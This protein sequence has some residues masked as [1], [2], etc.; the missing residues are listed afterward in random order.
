MK[1]VPAVFSKEYIESLSRVLSDF[2][3]AAFEAMIEEL[4]GAYHAEKTIFVMGNGG[5]AS[6][7]SHWVCDINKGCAGG[8]EKRFRMMCLND[9]VSTLLAYANDMAYERVFAEQLIN[10]FRPGDVVIGVSGSGNSK[11]V[12][13]AIEYANTH[14]GRTVGLSGFDGGRLAGMVHVP[15]VARVHDMQK[16]EDVHMIVVHMAMQR[17]RL[18][19]GLSATGC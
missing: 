18:A 1:G 6:T 10:F 5:S 2:P 13:N 8:A 11:N 17:I 14:G 15:V 12:L 16:V 3:H 19:L 4:L 7:A 9:S